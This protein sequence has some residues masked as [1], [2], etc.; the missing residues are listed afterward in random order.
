MITQ[1][2]KSQKSGFLGRWSRMFSSSSEYISLMDEFSDDISHSEDNSNDDPEDGETV[3]DV[4]NT[5]NEKQKTVVYAL[6][7]QI[8]EDSDNGES[9]EK[10]EKLEGGNFKYRVIILILTLYK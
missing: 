7:G 10:N 5:L 3:A 6:L 4:F 8:L 9:D 2:L 1:A